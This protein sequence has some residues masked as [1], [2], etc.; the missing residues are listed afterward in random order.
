MAPTFYCNYCD[1][2]YTE[3]YAHDSGVD[4]I[5]NLFQSDLT[6][7]DLTVKSFFFKNEDPQLTDLPEF[8]AIKKNEIVDKLRFILDNYTEVKIKIN[9]YLIRTDSSKNEKRGLSIVTKY[10]NSPPISDLESVYDHFVSKNLEIKEVLSPTPLPAEPTSASSTSLNEDVVIGDEEAPAVAGPGAL[11]LPAVPPSA[12]S[13]SLNEDDVIGDEEAPSAS[14]A[15]AV[16]E[17]L[18]GV[19][20]RFLEGKFARFCEICEDFYLKTS[21]HNRTFD[22]LRNLFGSDEQVREMPA[23]ARGQLRTFFIKNTDPS[24]L[25]TDLH[26]KKIK[27]LI[28]QILK[29]TLSQLQTIKSNII[30]H[31]EYIL[32]REGEIQGVSFKTK[33]YN[34]Y[35]EADCQNTYLLFESSIKKESADFYLKGSGWT[36]SKIIGSELRVNKFNVVASSGSSYLPLPISSSYVVN[37][38]NRDSRCFM[39]AMLAKYVSKGGRERPSSYEQYLDKYDFSCVNFPVEIEEI[40]KFEKR[41][42][43]SVSVFGLGR[44][45]DK[46][47]IRVFPIRVSLR[48]IENRH[49]DLLYI[50]DESESKFH[51]C[52][53]SN[54]DSLVRKQITK[55]KRRIYICKKCFAHKYSPEDLTA[56]KK[57]C[58]AISSDLFIASAPRDLV[59][60][61]KDENKMIPNNFLVF[62]D[63]E[64]YLEKI[65]HEPGLNSFN[66]R[67]HQ[68]LSYAYLIVS[69]DPNFNTPSPV[70]YRGKDPHVHFVKKMIEIAQEINESYNDRNSEIIMSPSDLLDFENASNCKICH[71]SF[72][73]PGVVKCRDHSHEYSPEGESNYRG[74]LCSLCNIKYRH[75]AHMTVVYHNG[76]KYDFKYVVQG[77][78]GLPYRV[79]IVP[80]S[81]ENFISIKVYVSQRFHIRFIDSYRFLPSS[82]DK[83]VSTLDES[84]FTYTRRFCSTPAQYRIARRKPVFCYDFV[85]SPDKL[86]LTEPPA[87]EH[88]YNSLTDTAVTPEDYANFLEAWKEFG[89][90][91]LGEYYDFYLC[92]DVNLLADLCLDFRAL[93]LKVYGLDCFNY[94]TLPS[95][96]FSAALKTTQARIKLFKDY[97]MTLMTM[98]GIRGG[99]V[100]VGKRYMK[101]NNPLCNDYDPSAPHS[102]GLY[103]DINS[104]YA[105]TMTLSLPYDDYR[106]LTADELSRLDVTAVPDD[107]PT[108]YVLDVSIA[109]PEH[110]HELHQGLPFLCNNELPPLPSAKQPRLLASFRDRENYIIHYVT[111]KQALRHGLRL[112]KINRAFSFSQKPFLKPF[113][114]KNIK[115]R[116]TLTSKFHQGVAKLLSNSCFGK[117]LQNP[118]KQRRIK[119]AVNSEQILKLVARVDFLDRTLFDEELAA[120]HMR[121]T[122]I[123]FDS[124]ILVGFAVLELSKVHMYRFYYD[125][126]IQRYGPTRC[127]NNYIDTDGLILEVFTENWWEDMKEMSDEWFDCSD[128]P[129]EH[130]CFSLKNRKRMGVM[131][132]ETCGKTIIEFVGLMSKMY[133]YRLGGGGEGMRAKGVPT[134]VLHATANF[135]VYKDVLFNKEKTHITE[136]RIQSKHMQL[137]SRESRKVALSSDDQKRY[138]LPDGVHT[139]PWGHR[140]IVEPQIWRET[141]K[142]AALRAHFLPG[143]SGNASNP[144]PCSDH[145][146]RYCFCS[147]ENAMLEKS[148]TALL[149]GIP[150]RPAFI[151]PSWLEKNGAYPLDS[152]EETFG[153]FGRCIVACIRLTGEPYRLRLPKDFDRA[154]TR[155]NI[156][157][158]NAGQYFLNYLGPFSQRSHKYSLSIRET[159]LPA[160]GPMPASPSPPPPPPPPP[161]SPERDGAEAA[162]PAEEE[163]GRGR[164]RRVSVSVNESGAMS[165]STAPASAG[166]RRPD[167]EDADLKRFRKFC[168]RQLPC[169]SRGPR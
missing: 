132:D 164:K 167:R 159:C 16:L 123:V 93:C 110:L 115:L 90:R 83:L 128:L 127:L 8:F 37:C 118:L 81:E 145:G 165:T 33:N 55:C 12:S 32:P 28:V 102:W 139:L 156:R 42:N 67:R 21:R 89:C 148:V 152:L 155:E 99:I 46:E 77:L 9:S 2:Y 49:T 31:S 146:I 82:L 141:N 45:G 44:V 38:K 6:V 160:P 70:L 59:K 78:Q 117:F 138:I 112:V 1:V 136:R 94:M 74:A 86:E 113:I 63:F 5:S 17:T 131:K 15:G 65:D 147:G 25:D 95:F 92:C 61:F 149:D 57:L 106:W 108:G 161:Q 53:I 96:G 140:D 26:L 73:A 39:Y 166:S 18:L 51:Y 47:T 29:D 130:P 133:A 157:E 27:F 40:G 36:I 129:P 50:T 4:H 114:E 143:G 19:E 58:Y 126:M 3:N 60:C 88:F 34:I 48:E 11:P 14:G 71:V 22:H 75:P 169:S 150:P 100:Q 10:V 104:L 7:E 109:Y 54:F 107:A 101:P 111:L 72:D 98:S 134:R 125:V 137:Y 163:A 158:I 124:A 168:E 84:A 162:A 64:S 43:C 142:I 41:N 120:V 135:E 144:E 91:T 76:S 79:E 119:L 35:H 87:P 56:H 62:A 13:T 151:H 80:A 66:F 105:H 122:E 153:K 97:E 116:Q 68:P 30:V 103:L 85:D 20:V 23:A 154:L 121:K 52:Y 24:V 69:T